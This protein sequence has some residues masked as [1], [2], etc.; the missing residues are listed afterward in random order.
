M[1][2]MM[3]RVIRVGSLNYVPYVISDFVVSF[4]KF[5]KEKL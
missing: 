5:S 2:N 1:K 3:G 4:M